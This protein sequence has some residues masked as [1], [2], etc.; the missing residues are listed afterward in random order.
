MDLPDDNSLEFSRSNG[1]SIPLD[2]NHPISSAIQIVHIEVTEALTR[3][4]SLQWQTGL[5]NS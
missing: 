1:Q 3:G 2:V 5:S 4:I